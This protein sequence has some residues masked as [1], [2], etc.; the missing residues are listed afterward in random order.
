MWKTDLI[1]SQA[2]LGNKFKF[3][4][5]RKKLNEGAVKIFAYIE[6]N[7]TANAANV[8]RGGP[9]TLDEASK[10]VVAM[11]KPAFLAQAPAAMSRWKD[12][13]GSTHAR[14]KRKA[15]QAQTEGGYC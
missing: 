15:Q 7:V 10:A 9:D 14:N 13:S 1:E 12:R 6:A 5:S 8:A 3:S 11:G 2:T 4:V